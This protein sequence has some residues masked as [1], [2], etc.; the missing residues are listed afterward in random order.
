MLGVFLGLFIGCS[1]VTI[2]IVYVISRYV[3]QLFDH[4]WWC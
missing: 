3:D 4:L 2:G 1:M